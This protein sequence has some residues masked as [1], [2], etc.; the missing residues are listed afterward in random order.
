M[1]DNKDKLAFIVE[2]AEII[3]QYQVAGLERWSLTSRPR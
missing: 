1:K 2:E 3:R